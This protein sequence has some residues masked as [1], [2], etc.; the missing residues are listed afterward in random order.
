MGLG[1]VNQKLSGKT[2]STKVS[3]VLEKPKGKVRA[4]LD[5]QGDTLKKQTNSFLFIYRQS[6][7]CLCYLESDYQGSNSGI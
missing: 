5:K 1:G 3:L 4:H 6:M 2:L 7:V